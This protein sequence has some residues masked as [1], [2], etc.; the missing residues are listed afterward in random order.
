MSESA[1]RVR[2]IFVPVRLTPVGDLVDVAVETVEMWEEI[3][4]HV[5][6]KVD[7]GR[8]LHSCRGFQPRELRSVW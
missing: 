3:V 8:T 6:A 5:I 2:T 7:I 1:G 4:L